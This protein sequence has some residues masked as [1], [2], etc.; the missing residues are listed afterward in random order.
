MAIGLG[1][2]KIVFF[3]GSFDRIG[4]SKEK[5]ANRLMLSEASR[6]DSIRNGEETWMM[7]WKLL[8]DSTSLFH[9]SWGSRA[10]PDAPS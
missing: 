4:F 1:E 2:Q 8:C 5:P 3:V 9:S 6:R 10:V 7:G